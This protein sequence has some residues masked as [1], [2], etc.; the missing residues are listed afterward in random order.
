[1]TS[2]KKPCVSWLSQEHLSIIE[3]S[4]W[5]DDIIINASQSLS[6]R[7]VSPCFGYV[8]KVL[9][10][11][12]CNFLLL[13]VSSVHFWGRT[14]ASVCKQV[15][16]CKFCMRVLTGCVSQHLAVHQAKSMRSIAYTQPT[17]QENGNDCGCF[18]VAYVETLC[19]GQ[20]PAIVQFKQSEMR[21]HLLQCL[22]TGELTPFP[23]TS[24]LSSAR[25]K[26]GKRH[27]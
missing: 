5:L 7:K 18:A 10:T 27:Q 19:Q 14:S 15:T 8:C 24:R 22:K 23:A 1:M 25:C 26:L 20:D 9:Y 17:R 4:A 2:R 12:W 21:A 13:Q 3:G 11:K 6:Q 16:S